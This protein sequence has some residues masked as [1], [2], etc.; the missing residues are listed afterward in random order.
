MRALF[1]GTFDPPSL[2]H[3]DLIERASK[4]CDELV[5]GIGVNPNK[6]TVFS[7]EKRMEMLH[8]I[9]KSLRNIQIVAISGLLVDF[10]HKNK[11]PLLIRGLRSF[12]ELDREMQL[13]IMNKNLTG[14]ETV[15]LPSNPLYA[16]ITS[17]LIRELILNKADLSSV[18]PASIQKK[19]LIQR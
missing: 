17:S 7:T 8:T 6:K 5:V 1:A 19:V 4:L 15:F 3:L 18:V 16:H 12:S 14:I 9:T 13:A 10:A 2:G 11:I